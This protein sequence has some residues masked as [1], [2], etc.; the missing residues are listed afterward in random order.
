[1]R[2]LLTWKIWGGD[3]EYAVINADSFDE[4]I[5]KAREIDP[6]YS[7]GQVIGFA[8]DAAD[9]LDEFDM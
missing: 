9:F 5:G 8:E 6:R 3:L 4:A 1:M 7:S 2:H